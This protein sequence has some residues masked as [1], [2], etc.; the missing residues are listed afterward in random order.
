MGQMSMKSW[1]RVIYDSLRMRM[2]MANKIRINSAACT[3]SGFL[4]TS[5]IFYSNFLSLLA[6][7]SLDPE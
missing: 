4:M 1:L 5:A 2:R 6:Y 7:L 3:F